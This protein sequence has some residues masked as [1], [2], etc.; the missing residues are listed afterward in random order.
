MEA[1]DLFRR[2]DIGQARICSKWGPR[3]STYQQWRIAAH[4]QRINGIRSCQIRSHVCTPGA[5]LHACLALLVA[6]RVGG[7][8]GTG[9]GCET[10]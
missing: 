5:N 4:S 10:S 8:S 3:R 2:R 1:R 7:S 9:G 6:M